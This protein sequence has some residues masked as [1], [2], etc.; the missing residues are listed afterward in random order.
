[1]QNFDGT[2]H[3]D[4]MISKKHDV[5]IDI[6]KKGVIK[7]A[8]KMFYD[9]IFDAVSE[10]Y[11][12]DIEPLKKKFRLSKIETYDEYFFADLFQ[13]DCAPCMNDSFAS[14]LVYEWKFGNK[15]EKT[16]IHRIPSDCQEA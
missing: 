7:Q 14:L 6:T 4:V 11:E 15:K 2:S 10:L 5:L 12:D 13:P 16:L 8:N 1:M 3:Q 9:W